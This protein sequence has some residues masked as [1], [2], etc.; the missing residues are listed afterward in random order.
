MTWSLNYLQTTVMN[1]FITNTILYVEIYDENIH[2]GVSF[3]YCLIIALIQTFTIKKSA[4]ILTKFRNDLAD[5]SKI[6]V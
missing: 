4:S 1:T 6:L 5:L 3:P 2:I